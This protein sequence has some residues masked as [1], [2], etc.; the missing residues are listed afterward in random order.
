MAGMATTVQTQPLAEVPEALEHVDVLIVGAGISGIGAAAHLVEALPAMSYAILE[1]RSAMGGTWDLFRYPGIRSDSD[2]HTLGFRFRPWH[3]DDVLADGPS[4]KQYVEET[5][6][7]YGITDH[8]RFG[9]HVTHASWD[10]ASRQ[11]TVRFEVDGEPGAITASFL[12]ACS[13]YYSYD[14]G[15]APEFAGVAD[16]RGQVVHPQFWP[17]DL[18]YAG[19]KVVVIGS[20][21]TAVTL[22]PA[23]AP[24]AG[25]VTMLQRSPSYIL[26]I[27]GNDPLG[28]ALR[29]VLPD[30]LAA[31]IARWRNVLI[32]AA[33]YQTSQRRPDFVRKAIRAA[34]V[35]QLP[36]DYDVDTHFKPSYDPW[37]QRMC[38]VP[39]GDLFRAIR[40]G[41]ASVVTAGI[42][43]FTERGILLDNGEELEADIIVTATGLKLQLFGGATLDIDGVKVDPH[44]RIVYKGAMLDGVPNFWFVIGYTNASWTLKADLVSEYVM[45]VLTRMR[46]NGERVVVPERSAEVRTVPL[47]PLAS[48]YIQR[49][50]PDLPQAGD[51]GQWQMPNNY[52]LD[53]VRLRRGKLHDGSLRFS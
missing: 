30:R 52:L 34:T 50:L 4:I 29:K 47:M 32:Q 8:V 36:K 16:F 10:S 1:R 45:R 5:A 25:H 35:K 15:H 43:R 53:I 24:D 14:E 26:S 13:G 31:G 44:E 28:P 48:G 22:V 42:D 39:D 17:E 9:H 37:D 2:M 23:M 3:N 33:L 11:W 38:M 40:K 41:K 49:A 6:A 7:E 51:R 21:A 27:P 18:D 12:W 19:K 20:G 46:R